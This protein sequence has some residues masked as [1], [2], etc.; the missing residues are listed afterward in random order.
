MGKVSDLRNRNGSGINGIMI[1]NSI[2]E[3]E[4]SRMGISINLIT[5]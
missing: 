2:K 1:R 4:K 5:V 3:S